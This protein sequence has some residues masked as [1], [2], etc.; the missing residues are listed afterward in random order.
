[1]FID[2]FFASKRRKWQLKFVNGPKKQ[3]RNAGAKKFLIVF[4]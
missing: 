4:F 2:A 1:M 3:A